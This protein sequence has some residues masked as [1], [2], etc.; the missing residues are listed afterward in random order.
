[1]LRPSARSKLAGTSA[2]SGASR[3][4]TG[5]NS[6]RSAR[7]ARSSSRAAAAAG[8]MPDRGSTRPRYLIRSAR[9]QVL[10]SCCAS[11]TA[12]CAARLTS[13]WLGTGPGSPGAARA[14]ARISPAVVPHRRRDRRQ[15]HAEGA[16]ERGRPARVQLRDIQRAVLGGARFE[17][18]RLREPRQFALRRRAAIALLERA[19][20]G[21]QVRGDRLA[22]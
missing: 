15:A 10:L 4:A 2:G 22:A 5:S 16:H 7:S 12:F 11:A 18:R 20:A 14:R 19:G 1:M 13:S 9:V 17:V 21:T 8:S 6:D 3:Q